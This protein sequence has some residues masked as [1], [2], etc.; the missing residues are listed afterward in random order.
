MYFTDRSSL[1]DKLADSL[2]GLR[3]TDSIL[4]CL[5]PSSMM[6]CVSMAVKLRAWI[7]PLFYENI[8]SPLDPTSLLGALTQNGD[9]CLDPAISPSQY[10]YVRQEFL[11]QLE[12][13]KREAMS[14]LNDTINSYYGTTDPNILNQRYVVL[15]GD[16]M[17]DALA[18]AVSR[19]LLKPLMPAKVYGAIGNTTIEVSNEIRLT[20]DEHYILD[21]LP[22]SVLG[23]DHYFEQP[24]PYDDEEKKTLAYNIALY[25]S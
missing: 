12:Q 7:L 16:V 1:G 6:A 9:F 18:L 13:D 21:I 10:D 22:S 2:T 17:F 24:D 5:K 8:K 3:G 15:V 11:V 19:S 20:A 23:A 25:W 14:R 4:V